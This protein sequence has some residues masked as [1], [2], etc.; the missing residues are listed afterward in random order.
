L[1]PTLL[2]LLTGCG[3]SGG[4][5]TS[6]GSTGGDA[7][8]STASVESDPNTGRS[9]GEDRSAS[10]EGSGPERPRS[11]RPG[12]PVLSLPSIPSGGGTVGDD[13]QLP[14]QCVDVNWL[15]KDPPPAGIRVSVASVRFSDPGFVVGGQ[16]CQGFS[17][18][19][20]NSGFGFGHDDARS[21]RCYLPLHADGRN[22]GNSVDLI[23]VG[24]F[25][26]PAGRQALCD[27]F[28]QR[29]AGDD[30]RISVTVPDQP[31]STTTATSD[32]SA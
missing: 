25:S 26:C 4:T 12:D 17:P 2:V 5:T 29:A 20:L 24:R 8:T 31:S 27:D 6:S 16:G 21:V 3:G 19:C 15:A 30:Q 9:E 23:L 14:D 22:G 32:S 28:V 18:P 13:Q 1:A 11:S 7:T 10:A